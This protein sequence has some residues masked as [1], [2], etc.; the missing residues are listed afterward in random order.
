[1]PAA[2][3][4]ILQASRITRTFGRGKSS[5]AVLKGIDL[6][7]PAG[8][9]VAL[10]GRSGSGKTTLINLLGA[11]DTPTEGIIELGGRDLTKLTGR[12]RDEL[13]RTE[14]GLI[15]QSFALVPLMTA[16]E[17]VEFML[18]VAGVPAKEREAA[19]IAAL[20]QVG[21]A[22]RMHHRPFELS[23]GEQQRTAIARAIARRPALVLADEPTAELDSRTGLT[24]MK[25][26]RELV[27]QGLTVVLTTHD[28]AIMEVADLVFELEDGHI[29]EV[30]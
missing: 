9:L 1:M 4:L 26:F 23:G 12:Q 6:A 10:K 15:F 29:A 16:Y 30:R 22:E 19:A 2:S 24:I 25:A 7:L 28:P 8:K 18:R 17:N 5:V 21:L 27:Q 14:I 3:P 13:R 11:L 20:E